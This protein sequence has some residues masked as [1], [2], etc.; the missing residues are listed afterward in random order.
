LRDTPDLNKVPT[1]VRRLLR[2]CLEKDPN[3]RLRHLGDAM[4]LVDESPRTAAI[5]VPSSAAPPA[6]NNWL[7]PAVAGLGFVAAAAIGF[8]HFREQPEVRPPVQF[9]FVQPKGSTRTLAGAFSLSPD[10]QTI[11]FAGITA[12]GP[13]WQIRRLDSTEIRTLDVPVPASNPY[14]PAWSPDSRHV[15]YGANNKIWKVDVQTS[16]T[17]ILCEPCDA[18]GASWGKDGTILLGDLRSISQIPENGGARKAVSKTLEATV[19]SVL[20]PIFMPDRK[21]YIY[22]WAVNGTNGK[23]GLRVTSTDSKPEEQSEEW[24]VESPAGAQWVPPSGNHPGYLLYVNSPNTLVARPFDPGKLA[25]TG[26]PI[27]IAQVEVQNN[28]GWAAFSASANGTLVYRP[29]I[30][31]QRQLTLF[32][33]TGRTISNVGDPGMIQTVVMSPD[34]TKTA[35]AIDGEDIWV[36]DLAAGTRTRLTSD[37]GPDGQPVWSHDG[38]WIYHNARRGTKGFIM[39]RP[40]SGASGEQIVYEFPDGSP[41]PNL[42]DISPDG[43]LLAYHQA[44]PQGVDIWTLDVSQ[45]GAKPQ[46]LVQT[47]AGE[48]AARFSPDGRYFLYRSNESGRFEVYA[49]AVPGYGAPAGKWLVSRNGSMGMGRW[50]HDSREAFFMS[51]DGSVMAAG[52]TLSPSFKADAPRKLFDVPSAFKLLLAGA[53][54]GA[55]VDMTPD[56]QRFLFAV[57]VTDASNVP[58]KVTTDWRASLAK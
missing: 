29:A 27:T 7:W 48:A 5:A 25:F 32:D 30:A 18:L 1:E 58:F 46:P 55:L 42:S 21:H 16:D 49:Q 53:T 4:S 15:V 38:A 43:K 13:R 36:S 56:G 54:P 6:K 26:E 33:Q 52:V 20:N 37:P 22:T 57:P 50:R 51:L 12:A 9:E 3:L 24:L 2:R 45:A 44:G 19:G 10:G 8:V 23:I 17:Q 41:A 31:N 11:I 35:L 14:A 39:R 47:A 40:S 34:G 28:L